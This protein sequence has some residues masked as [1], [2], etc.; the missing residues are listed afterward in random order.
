MNVL[1]KYL[2]NKFIKL[3][4]IITFFLF[5]ILLINQFFLVMKE[6][7]SIPFKADEILKIIFLKGVNDLPQLISICLYTALFIGITRLTNNNE[8]FILYSSGISNNLLLHI[9]SP[10]IIACITISLLITVFLGPF[11]ESEIQTQREFAKANMHRISLSEKTINSFNEGEM[12][13]YVDKL[14]EPTGENVQ[15]FENFLII[16]TS[17][18]QSNIV[19]S[20]YGKKENFS[21]STLFKLRDGTKYTVNREF[22]LDSITN[23]SNLE[24]VINHTK[25]DSGMEIN[26]SLINTIDLLNQLIKPEYAAEIFWRFSVPLSIF[27]LSFFAIYSIKLAPRAVK[28]FNYLKLLVLL[29]VYNSILL[30]VKSEIGDGNL[31]LILSLFI[32]HLVPVAI[33]LKIIFLKKNFISSKN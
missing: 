2:L 20:D 9:L 29:I 10:L 27:S 1:N 12:I 3:T 23:F 13:I 26:I 24:L 8:I 28:N 31:D 30:I 7:N 15:N 25:K 33:F 32:L 16:E 21:D 14:I 18:N 17:K 11:I 4:L 6:A 5:A 22:K 19:I